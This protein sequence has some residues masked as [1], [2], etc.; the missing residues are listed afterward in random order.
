MEK[1]DGVWHIKKNWFL[2]YVW[3][4]NLYRYP[5]ERKYPNNLC[6]LCRGS[7]L[8]GMVF[9]PI[10]LCIIIVLSCFYFVV[11]VVVV[12][13]GFYFSPEYNI[14]YKKIQWKGK[15][16]RIPIAAWE[17]CVVG[18]VIYLLVKHWS[19]IFDT[20]KTAV[21]NYGVLMGQI[22]FGAIVLF[23][24]FLFLTTVGK[25]TCKLIWDFLK[26]TKR[27]VCPLIK[28]ED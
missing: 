10:V 12:F 2:K 5:D 20:T 1:K 19:V 9:L 22:G 23:L 4:L 21:Q 17:I 14:G 16:K 7:S 25:N 6:S 15:M 8:L 3:G 24:I 11:I 28:I 13:F 27:K 18:G 26:A